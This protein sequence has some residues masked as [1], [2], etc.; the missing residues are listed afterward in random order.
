[1]IHRAVGAADQAEGLARVV[2]VQA[3][4]GTVGLGTELGGAAPARR[5][6]ELQAPVGDKAQHIGTRSPVPR[7]GQRSLTV[8]IRTRSKA[9]ARR[10]AAAGPRP[11][12]KMWSPL[13]HSGDQPRIYR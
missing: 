9:S 11:I 1:M 10:V 3:G 6:A 7:A 5:R 8:T 4:P 12:P 2:A 13:H